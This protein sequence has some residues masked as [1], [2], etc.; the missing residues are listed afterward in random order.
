MLHLQ[1]RIEEKFPTTPVPLRTGKLTHLFLNLQ[2]AET[3]ST[4]RRKPK[5][6]GLLE[7]NKWKKLLASTHTKDAKQAARE[8]VESFASRS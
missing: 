1:V 7:E 2:T 5:H 6:K 4:P 8:C 3:K